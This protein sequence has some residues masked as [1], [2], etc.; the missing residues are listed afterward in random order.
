VGLG[1]VALLQAADR[2]P[3]AP[4]VRFTGEVER[5]AELIREKKIVS[6][7]QALTCVPKQARGQL[8][9]VLFREASEEADGRPAYEVFVLSE[10]RLVRVTVLDAASGNVLVERRVGVSSGDR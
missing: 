4:G 10:D 6:V 2:G 1:A 3:A 9:Q 5:A 7:G 8:L